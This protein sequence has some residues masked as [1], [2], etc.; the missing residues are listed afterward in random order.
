MKRTPSPW[1]CGVCGLGVTPWMGKGW[2]HQ[3]G[4]NTISCKRPPRPVKREVY[5]QE[6]KAIVAYVKERSAHGKERKT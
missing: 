3:A 1:V 6:L 2:K 5:E 4:G